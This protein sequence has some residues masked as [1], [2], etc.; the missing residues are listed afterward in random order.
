VIGDVTD[1]T[2]FKAKMVSAEEFSKAYLSKHG[3][4]AYN[5]NSLEFAMLNNF[6]I[7]KD[8]MRKVVKF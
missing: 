2:M 8:K 6:T 5:T 4:Q 7:A 3:D 1:V